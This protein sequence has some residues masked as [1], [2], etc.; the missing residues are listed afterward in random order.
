MVHQPAR[1]SEEATIHPTGTAIQTAGA[2]AGVIPVQ[3]ALVIA[4]TIAIQRVIL[5]PLGEMRASMY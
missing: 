5:I 3:T 1:E 2:M 4:G